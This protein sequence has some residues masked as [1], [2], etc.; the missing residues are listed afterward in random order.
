M[1][2]STFLRRQAPSYPQHFTLF[3]TLPLQ[4]LMLTSPRPLMAKGP[5]HERTEKENRRD[6]TPSE[7]GDLLPTPQARTRMSGS[8]V[9]HS[10]DPECRSLHL[11]TLAGGAA[12]SLGRWTL[13]DK[14]MVQSSLVQCTAG[15]GFLPAFACCGL[16]HRILK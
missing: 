15:S 7:L 14:P 3:W 5:G 9:V 4:L 8:P 13:G 6:F 1:H 16:L 10:S 2:F 12:L 11:G